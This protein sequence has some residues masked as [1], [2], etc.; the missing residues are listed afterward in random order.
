VRER[1]RE[2]ESEG[3][4]RVSELGT[5]RL[6]RGAR[7]GRDPGFLW[8]R[9]FGSMYSLG[10]RWFSVNALATSPVV[11]HNNVG[12]VSTLASKNCHWFQLV[13]TELELDCNW[14]RNWSLV[15]FLEEPDQFPVVIRCGART[16][17]EIF[18]K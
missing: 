5:S 3:R 14:N 1:E 4:D 18:E 17:I 12:Q 16:G 9:F 6:W 10:N 7:E 13:R 15:L 11:V 2:R 8:V